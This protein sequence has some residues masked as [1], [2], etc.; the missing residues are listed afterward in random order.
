MF[1]TLIL[2]SALAVFIFGCSK[3]SGSVGPGSSAAQSSG[4]ATQPAQNVA[5]DLRSKV[6][7]GWTTEKPT[8]DMRVAQY[9]LPHA[10]GDTED[11]LLVVYYF[12]KGQG[13]SADANIERW[14]NQVKQPDGQPSQDRAKIGSQTVNGLAVKTV[15]VSGN[16]GG[17][18]S[19][20]SAPTNS[21]TIYRLRGAVVETPKGSYFVKLT[22]PENTIKR[23]EQAYNDYLQSLDFK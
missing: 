20:D 19:P 5:G 22:G 1:K 12:G 3:N 16:Y 4:S 14:V 21:K 15:D 8:S 9:K 2:L 17:G 10:D 11:G 7:D 6:P 13:G 18:M 23:W